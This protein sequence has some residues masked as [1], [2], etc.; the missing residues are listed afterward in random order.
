MEGSMGYVWFFI[1]AI[2][3]LSVANLGMF[4]YTVRGFAEK[5]TLLSHVAVQY[6]NEKEVEEVQKKS[7]ETQGRTP[8][9]MRVATE[10]FVTRR[11]R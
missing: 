11:Q 1:A 7:E 8:K 10:E 5:L 3:L 4:I 6:L 9:V 2:G